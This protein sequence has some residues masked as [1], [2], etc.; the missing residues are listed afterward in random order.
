[1]LANQALVPHIG[2]GEAVT[3][4]PPCVVRLSPNLLDGAT[5]DVPLQLT[6]G[7]G[8][9]WQDRVHLLACAPEPE[10]VH[11]QST[12]GPPGH[13]AVSIEMKN[14][15]TGS[16]PAWTGI[17]TPDDPDSTVQLV[18]GA[19]PF[20]PLP[21]HATASGLAPFEIVS[22]LSK[23]P[24]GIFSFVDPYGRTLSL[25]GD[26]RARAPPSLPV[27]DLAFAAGTVHLSWPTGGNPDGFGYHVFRAT[28]G[29]PSFARLTPDMIRHADY[30]D[31]TVEAN[32][33][34]D[35]YV[36]AVDSSRQWSIA[37]PVLGV[38]TTAALLP[39]W[40][41]EVIDPTASSV[42]VG[43]LDGDGSPEIVLDDRG[44]YA[45]HANGHEIRD[46]DNNATT[47]GVLSTAPGVM[48]ASVALAHIDNQ[49]GLE[50]VAASWLTNKIF[51]MN[52][53][54]TVLPG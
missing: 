25:H 31:T 53:H 37:S 18:Q 49:P 54:G 16:Q 15:G 6:D 17:Y 24:P 50:I 26:G 22:P 20:A 48:N 14:F 5:I 23:L 45:W 32:T 46:G 27:A 28:A 21:G 12:L 33:H 30:F 43:D 34:Y 9:V 51:V 2:A 41:T 39:G 4:S 35:Y 7:A 38:N 42:G 36:V 40:P 1:I 52:A 47:D 19:M 29:N 13:V 10:I 44:V 3:A 11:V 8:G